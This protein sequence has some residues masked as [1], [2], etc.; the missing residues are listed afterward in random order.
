MTA[1]KKFGAQSCMKW[2]VARCVGIPWTRD[3]SD[4]CTT[5]A[6]VSLHETSFLH[7]STKMARAIKAKARPKM[8]PI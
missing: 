6:H 2:A 7:Q 5:A 3:V 8:L 4:G 1:A